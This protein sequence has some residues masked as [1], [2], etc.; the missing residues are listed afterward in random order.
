MAVLRK[1]STPTVRVKVAGDLTGHTC[2]LAFGKG[3]RP[4]FTC[5]NTQMEMFVE[6]GC[7]VL[8]FTLTQEQTLKCRKGVT[9]LQLRVVKDGIALVS[10]MHEVTVA[11]VIYAEVI[12]DELY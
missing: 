4:T 9:Y 5:D 2:Q 8:A 10:E 3:S 7:T 6:D 1:G 12:E 11:D